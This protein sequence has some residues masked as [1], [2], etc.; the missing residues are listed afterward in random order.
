MAKKYLEDMPNEMKGIIKYQNISKDVYNYPLRIVQKLKYKSH[1]K[2]PNKKYFCELTKNNWLSL[3]NTPNAIY[4]KVGSQLVKCSN[5]DFPINEEYI[6][7]VTHIDGP[8]IICNGV[9]INT[10][11]YLIYRG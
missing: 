3:K 7:I 8:N 6:I 10:M 2:S 11:E 9:I 4:S 1:V 5:I